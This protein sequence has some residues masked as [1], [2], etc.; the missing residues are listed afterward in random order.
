MSEGFK[1][2]VCVSVLMVV[3]GEFHL[4]AEENIFPPWM[5]V[6]ILFYTL[7]LWIDERLVPLIKDIDDLFKKG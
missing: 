3:I 6:I 2:V 4:F 7:V 5:Y 1:I